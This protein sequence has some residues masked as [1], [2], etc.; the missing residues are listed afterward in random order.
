MSVG[1]DEVA[2]NVSSGSIGGG[3]EGGGSGKL[4]FFDLSKIFFSLFLS[5]F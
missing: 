4:H 1:S 3:D 2:R 5:I